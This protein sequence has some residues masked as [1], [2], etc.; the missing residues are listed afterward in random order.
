MSGGTYYRHNR[1]ARAAK[2]LKELKAKTV[3]S[4]GENKENAEVVGWDETRNLKRARDA[5]EEEGNA[6]DASR[7]VK[8][9]IE[10]DEH[11]QHASALVRPISWSLSGAV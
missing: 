4:S 2:A 1:V 3:G 6:E 11:I 10:G 7:I 9:R 5:S 8:R